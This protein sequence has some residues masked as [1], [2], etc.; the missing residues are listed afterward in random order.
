MNERTYL[1]TIIK[2]CKFQI[3]MLDENIQVY[4]DDTEQVIGF[5]K[6]KQNY[7]FMI[8]RLIVKFY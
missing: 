2:D 5:K 7:Q 1:N 6:R 3:R 8:D 4:S